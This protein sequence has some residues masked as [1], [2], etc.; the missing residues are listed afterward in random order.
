MPKEVK[1]YSTEMCPWCVKAKEFLKEHK[2]KFK[3]ID[4]AEDEKGREEMIEKSGQMGVPVIMVKDGEKEEVIVGFD[5]GR[6]KKVL[7]LK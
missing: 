7:G 6:L 1:V 5:E 4:I 3:A 2:V